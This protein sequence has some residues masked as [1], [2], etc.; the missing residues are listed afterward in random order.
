M[1]FVV[2]QT[3]G[4]QVETVHPVSAV[5]AS[6]TTRLWSTGP[7]LGSFWRSGNKP[8]QLMNSL[9]NLPP[10]VVS[11]LDPRDLAL[12]A[13]SH[14]GQERHVRRVAELLGRFGLDAT[15]LRCG[16]HWP[17][18]EES[19]RA[20]AARG[21]T[22]SVLHSNCSGKHTFM[23]AASHARGWDLDYRSIDH[24]LQQGNLARMTEWMDHAPTHAV[25]GCSIP[26]FYAPI[27]A[28]ARAWARLAAAM[29]DTPDT[30]AGRIGWAMHQHPEYMSGDE[31]LDLIVVQ[32]ARRRLTVKIG[33]EGLFCIALP[34]ERLGLVVKVHTGNTDALATAVHAL[35]E[36]HFPGTLPEA[37]SWNVV[38]NIAGLEVGA[39]V[40]RDR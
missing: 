3:R 33:A 36:E 2:E 1:P 30:P 38:R 17:M 6:P 15:G 34:D 29:A 12:G 11:A 37:W 8:F 16:A 19:A 28:M 14:S 40:A 23:L 25:D 20:L 27:S 18:H 5:L 7:D 31:R 35:L 13:S 9:S 39:R 24:P 10:E 4:G 22:C 21:E 26:T 32:S